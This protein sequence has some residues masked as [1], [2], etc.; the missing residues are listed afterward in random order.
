[1]PSARFLVPFLTILALAPAR[2]AAQTDFVLPDTTAL[3]AEERAL[4]RFEQA[5]SAAIARHDTTVLR[6][7]YADEFRGITALGI[8]VDRER[9]LGVFTRDDPSTVFTIDELAV[10]TLGRGGAAVLTGRLTTRRRATGETVARSRFTHV[11]EWRD[12]RWRI[13]AAQGTAL[14]ADAS[15]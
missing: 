14:A 4:L 12:G 3:G 2:A 1:M 11:Y 9:L 13:V 6:R 15:G 7:M 5:R 8:P 10:R